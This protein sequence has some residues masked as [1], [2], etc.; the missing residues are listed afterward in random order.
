MESS[1]KKSQQIDNGKKIKYAKNML[2]FLN[3]FFG[4]LFHMINKKFSSFVIKKQQL[5]SN[6]WVN[7]KGRILMKKQINQSG[8]NCF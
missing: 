5:S 2:C 1:K 4:P 6:V 8:A 3:Y 7:R